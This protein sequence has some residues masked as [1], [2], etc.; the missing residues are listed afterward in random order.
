MGLSDTHTH[1]HTHTHIIPHPSR[2]IGK[3]L[4][5]FIRLS[6]LPSFSLFVSSA[7]YIHLSLLPPVLQYFRQHFII[8]IR[9]HLSGLVHRVIDP[10]LW[11]F[12]FLQLH[13]VR[14]LTIGE[15]HRLAGSSASVC[16]L[17]VCVW[18]LLLNLSQIWILCS[19]KTKS[20]T[21]NYFLLHMRLFLCV[22]LCL[23][24]GFEFCSRICV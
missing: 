7:P 8:L 5:N 14:V 21:P 16:L 18:H 22:S 17:F 4:S 6:L 10:L 9:K 15:M 3:L 12:Y 23:S 1:T 24:G 13:S 19:Y 20:K 2:Q 11:G